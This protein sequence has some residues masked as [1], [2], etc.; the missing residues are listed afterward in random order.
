MSYLYIIGLYIKYLQNENMHT[1]NT[2]SSFT[3][4]IWSKIYFDNVQAF[5]KDTLNEQFC[6]CMHFW[7]LEVFFLNPKGTNLKIWAKKIQIEF[8]D[9]WSSNKV[10]RWERVCIHNQKLNYNTELVKIVDLRLALWTFVNWVFWYFPHDSKIQ[11]CN[12]RIV[13]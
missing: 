9:L 12:L 11:L 6:N 13:F 5:F 2:M 8:W 1:Q 4:M 7:N 3:D 10:L